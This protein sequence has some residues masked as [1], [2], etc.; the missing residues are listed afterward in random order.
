MT[1]KEKSRNERHG[2]SFSRAKSMHCSAK[3][4]Q[5][6]SIIARKTQLIEAFGCQNFGYLRRR[7]DSDELFYQRLL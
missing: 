4:R 2:L 3:R 7:V 6:K 1:Y 5:R